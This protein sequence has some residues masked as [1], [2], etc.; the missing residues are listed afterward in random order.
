MTLLDCSR[1]NE[2]FIHNCNHGEDAGVICTGNS[3]LFSNN[4]MNIS[5]NITMI[6]THGINLYTVL[7][8]WKWKNN[9]MIQNQLNSFQ[10]ECLSNQH[11]IEMSVNSTTFSI[12]LL[13]LL[14][15]TSYNCCVSAVY[16]SQIAR[17]VCTEITTIQPPTQT[18]ETPLMH[19]SGGT[20]VK[21][22]GG[23]TIK[24]STC[25]IQECSSKASSSADKIGGV[26]GFI[27]AVLLILLA[28]SVA[29]LVYLLR[30]KFLRNSVPKQ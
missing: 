10:I 8:T 21:P 25:Q 1:D 3:S 9:S 19:P 22:E 23:S 30:P 16:G 12:E 28:V 5:I 6:S 29:A 26:L 7:I 2:L 17:A 24:P 4:V 11:R 27:I 18:S 14:S 15:S 20:T 13:G